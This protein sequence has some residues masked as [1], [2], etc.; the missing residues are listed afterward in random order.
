MSTLAKALLAVWA[1]MSVITFFVYGYDK[2][3]ARKGGWRVPEAR[4]LLLAACFGALG[5]LAGMRVFHH[6]TLHTSFRILVPLFTALNA[7][8]FAGVCIWS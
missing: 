1:V 8:I 3:M 7:A 5:A 2:R 6:K 4:L